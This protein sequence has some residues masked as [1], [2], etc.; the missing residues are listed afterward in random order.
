[1]RRLLSDTSG[2]TT[3]PTLTLH[4]TPP[5]S[6]FF[7]CH[8][9]DRDVH[10]GGETEESGG[11]EDNPPHWRTEDDHT[12]SDGGGWTSPGHS[13]GPARYQH[14]AVRQGLQP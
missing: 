14:T 7:V 8:I 1:M 10:Q 12:S 3:N 13:A 11:G 4:Y 5:T 9:G 2:A 6:T